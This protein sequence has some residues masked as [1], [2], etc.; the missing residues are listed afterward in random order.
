MAVAEAEK[1]ECIVY[2]ALVL[3]GAEC[4]RPAFAE[5]VAKDVFRLLAPD[6]YSPEHEEWEFAPGSIVRCE[7][8]MLDDGEYLV[9]VELVQDGA[10]RAA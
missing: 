1:E 5:P 4:W 7:S 10:T 2:V 8:T 6:D 9:A 3:E